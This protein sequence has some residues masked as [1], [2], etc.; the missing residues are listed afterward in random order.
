VAALWVPVLVAALWVPVLVAAL[1][2][3]VLVAALWHFD[4]EYRTTICPHEAFAANDGK[5]NF[6]V[7]EDAY[8]APEPPPRR[9]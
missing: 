3:P 9:H 4:D 1:W 8:L 2:V 6:R 7:H 5:N